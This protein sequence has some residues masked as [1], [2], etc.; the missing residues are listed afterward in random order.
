MRPG[1][2]LDPAG[3]D[4]PFDAL[5]RALRDGDG[6]AWERVFDELLPRVKSALRQEFGTEVARSDNAGGQALAPAFR[7]LYRHLTAGGFQLECWD[8]LAGLL[9]R[10]AS[11]KCLDRLKE[12]RRLVNWT[13]LRDPSSES[14]AG[15]Q[16]V[17]PGRSPEDAILRAEAC[18]ALKRAVDKVRRQLKRS[19][20]NGTGKA[21]EIFR[22]RL[23]G[24]YTNAEIA[25]LVGRSERTVERAWRD[26]VDLLKGML[27]GS[28][29]DERID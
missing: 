26:A 5:V 13:D 23:E 4:L 19:D 15:P 12:G 8:D 29:G 18:D 9:I 21:A 24:V 11:Q 10:I 27:D 1:R 17:D 14:G 6:A 28:V 16:P 3:A 7:T 25:A 2:D 22:L 20:Q